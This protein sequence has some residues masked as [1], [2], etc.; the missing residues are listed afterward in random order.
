MAYSRDDAVRI[1]RGFLRKA[2]LRHRIRRA[3]L[4]GSSVWGRPKEYSDIDLAVVLETSPVPSGTDFDESF[5]I[6]HEAQ[7][8]NS[9]LEVAC[10]TLEEFES[11][12]VTLVRWIKKEGL[13]IPLAMEE[14][15]ELR[16]ASR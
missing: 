11:G 3:F 8:H 12:S 13:E 5:E 2:S 16:G 15:E 6:F 10:F 4:F 14:E 1:A 9:A 7:E